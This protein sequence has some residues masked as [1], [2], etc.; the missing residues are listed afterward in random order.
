MSDFPF[1][2]KKARS[3]FNRVW[4]AVGGDLMEA[5]AGEPIHRDDLFDYAFGGGLE[6]YGEPE[7]ELLK[8]LQ[9][10]DIKT[11]MA[12]VPLVYDYEEMS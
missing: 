2:L 6:Q 9:D 10:S 12:L 7:P 11:V 8:W 1:D 3:S 5:S 4:N